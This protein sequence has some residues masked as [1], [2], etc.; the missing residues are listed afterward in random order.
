[1]APDPAGRAG[2]GD[3]GDVL[4]CVHASLTGPEGRM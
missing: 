3:P 2:D 1:V 4:V